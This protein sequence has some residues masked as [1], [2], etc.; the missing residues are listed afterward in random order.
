MRTLGIIIGGLALLGAFALVGSR[1]G[2]GNAGAIAALKIF[3]PVWLAAA[4]VNMWFGV[5]RAGYSVSDEFPIL[6]AI[7]AVPTAVAA[8]VW[9][10]LA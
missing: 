7:F 1:M 2:S 5:S 10:K 9:W 8:L 4:L 3:V 6:L